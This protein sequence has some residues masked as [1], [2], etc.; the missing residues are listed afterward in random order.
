MPTK[1]RLFDVID[2]N[3]NTGSF[4][5]LKDGLIYE[6]PSNMSTYGTTFTPNAVSH[7]IY[8]KVLELESKGITDEVMGIEFSKLALLEILM[9]DGCEGIR[10]VKCK[11]LNA[12]NSGISLEEDSLVAMGLDSNGEL[13]GKSWYNQNNKTL[14][15]DPMPIAKE[16]GNTTLI[17]TIKKEMNS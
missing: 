16:K 3:S 2:F 14:L 6:I 12:D 1:I 4:E 5:E 9:Q 17:A 11:A 8:S 15:L 7:M 10:F 13:I